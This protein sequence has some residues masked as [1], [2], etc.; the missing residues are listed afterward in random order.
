MLPTL[1]RRACSGVAST[2][3]QPGMPPIRWTHLPEQLP[4]AL[5]LLLQESLVQRR[6]EA[7]K[8]LSLAPPASPTTPIDPSLQRWASTD[9]LL[10]L[11]HRPVFTAG[12]REKDPVV[13]AAEAARLGE[14]GADYVQT[15]RGG[16]TTYHG[17]GQLVGYP[18][19][20]LG[21]AGVSVH[22]FYPL[23]R[24]PPLIPWSNLGSSQPVATSPTSN[25]SSNPSSPPSKSPST[26]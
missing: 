17:P 12:K 21:A 23:A 5:G 10:L 3:V 22:P 2:T 14:M 25:L 20:D 4:Y 11:Q 7:K 15:M 19:M 24:Y 26:L 16:Q 9:V 1:L 13:A 6:L 8:E 18:L